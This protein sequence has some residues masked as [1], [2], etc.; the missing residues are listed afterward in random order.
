[1]KF[2]H[3]E[4]DLGFKI[5]GKVASRLS[6]LGVAVKRGDVVARLDEQDRRNDYLAAQ[7]NLDS[8]QASLTKTSAEERRQKQLRT[9]GWSTAATYE[10]A[11]QARDVA[12]ANLRAA[13]AKS[14][15]AHD[16]LGDSWLRAPEDGVVTALGAEA[17][18]VV[19]A[20]QMVIRMARQDHKDAVFSIAESALAAVLRHAP[21]DV[22]SLDDPTVRSRGEVTEISPSADPMTRTYTVKVALPDGTPGLRFGMTVVGSVH[23]AERPVIGLPGSALFQQEGRD[24]RSG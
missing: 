3:F 4:S 17:G 14:R 24:R 13:E 19:A 9:D 1:V 23:T 6:E 5:A 15:L 21:V 2:V 20:G 22:W 10:S 12:Q 11:L 7:A 18:Q 8:A 16:Q